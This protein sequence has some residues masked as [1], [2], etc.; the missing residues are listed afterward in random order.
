MMS[1]FG[2]IVALDNLGSTLQNTFAA[3]N[4][5]EADSFQVAD[6]DKRCFLWQV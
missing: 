1:S 4:S 2:P 5:T 6:K 3:G